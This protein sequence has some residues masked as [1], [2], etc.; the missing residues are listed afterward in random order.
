MAMATRRER[1]L[2]DPDAAPGRSPFDHQIYCICSDG[3][4]QEGVS[5]EA[6]S[7][8]GVQ[9]LGNLTLIYDNNRISIEDDTSIALSEDTAARYAAYGWHV[10]TV[11]WF[12]NGTATTENVKALEDA[13][14]AAH[15]VTDRPSFIDL[16]TVIAWPSP[17][18]QNS[19]SAHGSAL[20]DDEVKGLK[21]VLGFDPEK[22]FEVSDEVI[23]HTRELLERGK[24]ARAEWQQTFDEW[25]Q[26]NPESKAFYE[27]MTE[28]ELT[29]GWEE[30]I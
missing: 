9:K 25:A 16:R 12:F 6:S 22:T 1:G 30:A 23:K 17:G 28:R 13:I 24:R 19:G 27:R 14:R 29:P 18:K 15:E 26:A 7:L 4:I 8:A 11:D 21:E 2:L 10:Q 5:S 20:G 3:D